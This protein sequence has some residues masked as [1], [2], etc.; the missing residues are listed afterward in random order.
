[1]SPSWRS[2]RAGPFPLAGRAWAATR[3]GA[4]S[5][6]RSSQRAPRRSPA[7]EGPVVETPRSWVEELGDE[8]GAYSGK[9]R[10]RQGVPPRRAE[11][12][13]QAGERVRALDAPDRLGEQPRDRD[14]PDL[15][16]G[17]GL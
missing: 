6:M 9:T 12:D 13:E 1:M 14:L 7:G 4:V 17:L 16:A 8:A 10:C 3:F 15:V 11:S 5:A 2:R